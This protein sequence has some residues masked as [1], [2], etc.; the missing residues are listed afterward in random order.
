MSSA[1]RNASAG[2]SPVT[3]IGWVPADPRGHERIRATHLRVGEQQGAA[4]VKRQRAARDRTLRS[5]GERRDHVLV[6]TDGAR[7]RRDALSVVL[8][9][10]TAVLPGR[11]QIE[12]GPE[13][14]GAH[15]RTPTSSCVMPPESWSRRAD[16]NP[17]ARSIAS[18]SAGGG[19][20]AIDRGR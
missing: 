11:E 4:A 3:R 18:I 14:L 10:H 6:A 8:D 16:G 19:R 13:V 7:T 20:Y 1:S 9:V 15:A 17:A 5:V 2:I 12:R